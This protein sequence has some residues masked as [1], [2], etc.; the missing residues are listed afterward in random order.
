MFNVASAKAAG[1]KLFSRKQDGFF[2]G[3]AYAIVDDTHVLLRQNPNKDSSYAVRARAGEKI[4]WVV[5]RDIIEGKRQG[6]FN[7]YGRYENGA[8]FDTDQRSF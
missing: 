5:D 4:G 2:R 1:E 3:L 7:Y 8:V 6:R